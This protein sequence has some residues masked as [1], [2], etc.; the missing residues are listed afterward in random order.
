MKFDLHT[1]I[2]VLIALVVFKI[3]DEL[4]LDKA[5]AKITEKFEE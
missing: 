3:I 2:N 1:V 4:F 5:V